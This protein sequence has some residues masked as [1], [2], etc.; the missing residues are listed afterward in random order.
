MMRWLILGVVLGLLLACPTLLG[1]VL[2]LVAVLVSQP[3]VV[4][5][6]LGAIFGRP[7]VHSLWRWAR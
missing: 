6:T 7:V 2:G 5:F 1:A 4:A 3:L